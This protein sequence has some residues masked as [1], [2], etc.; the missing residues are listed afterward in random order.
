MQYTDKQTSEE[1]R[2]V[3][4]L[5]M[6]RAGLRGLEFYDPKTKRHRQAHTQARLGITQHLIKAGLV[7]LEEIRS[8]S[9]ALE[10]AHIRVDRAAVISCGADVAGK[11]L[12]ELQVRK[13]TADGVGARDFYTDLTTPFSGWEG[14]LRDLVI[15]KKQPGKIFVQPNTFVNGDEVVLKEYPLTAAGVIESFIE[16]DI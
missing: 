3:T 11:L 13:S 2:Y 4:F 16:R 15:R 9:G 6:A 10:N 1:L 14:E 7:S 12:L 8:S 5:I